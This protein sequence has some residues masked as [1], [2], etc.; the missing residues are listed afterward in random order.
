MLNN[1]SLRCGGYVRKNDSGATG[2]YEDSPPSAVVP[3]QEPRGFGRI[4][5][6]CEE[7]VPHSPLQR[8]W[9]PNGQDIP[10]RSHAV[11]QLRDL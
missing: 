3:L 5:G 8:E 1:S 10:V 7:G 6:Y 11:H 4:N 9:S 2:S